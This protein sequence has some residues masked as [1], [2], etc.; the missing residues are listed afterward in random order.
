MELSSLPE[1]FLFQNANGYCF[2]IPEFTGVIT[3][4]T[5]QVTSVG[6]GLW[7][8]PMGNSGAATGAEEVGVKRKNNADELPHGF[9]LT[10]ELVNYEAYKGFFARDNNGGEIVKIGLHHDCCFQPTD[11]VVAS[12]AAE[13][14]V[15]AA[16]P[17]ATGAAGVSCAAT[18][19]VSCPVNVI[20]GTWI[21]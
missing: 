8:E 9:G 16:I 18:T 12:S 2:S 19:V 14:V 6:L 20:Q 17:A 21:Y 5:D 4:P 7:N 11:P 13:S 10:N 3:A 1:A 15:T